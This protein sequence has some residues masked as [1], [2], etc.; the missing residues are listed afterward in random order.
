MYIKR[1][2][3]P[4]YGIQKK[5]FFLFGPRSIGKSLLIKKIIQDDT[6]YLSLLSTDLFLRLSERPALL[7]GIIKDYKIVVIDEIQKLPILLDEIHRLIGEKD[8]HF[9]LTGSSARRLKR[10]CANLLGGRANQLH[11]YPLT[12]FEIQNF[13]LDRYLLWGGLP[14]V[15]L[16]DDPM[17]ELEGYLQIYL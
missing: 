12:S 9:L 8:I 7:E 5:S 4:F 3:N 17:F 10:E 16:S 13:D 15:H 2:I 14:R 11:L 1:A 6:L